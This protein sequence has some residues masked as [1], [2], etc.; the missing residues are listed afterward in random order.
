MTSGRADMAG[1]M[2]DVAQHIMKAERLANV[3]TGLHAQTHMGAPDF[4][5]LFESFAREDQALPPPRVFFCGPAPL[6]RT[7][8]RSCHRLGLPFRSERF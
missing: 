6:G 7:V 3:V 1:G 4:D 5:R 2:L 8:A